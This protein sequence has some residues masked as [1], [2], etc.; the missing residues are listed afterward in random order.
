PQETIILSRGGITPE[1]LAT[2]AIGNALNFLEHPEAAL[3]LYQEGLL[4]NDLLQKHWQLRDQLLTHPI[5]AI[6]LSKTSV[7]PEVLATYSIHDIPDLFKRSE[8]ILKLHQTCPFSHDFLLKHPKLRDQLL[9]NPQQAITLSAGGMTPEVLA[10]YS[11]DDVQNFLWHPEAALALYQEGLLNNVFLQQ[12]PLLRDKFLSNPQEAITLSAGGMTPEVLATYSTDDVQNF[13]WH[14]ERALALYQEGLLNNDFLQQHPRLRD[15]FLL[16]PQ[17][18][19][20]L[21]KGGMTPEVLATYARGNALAF[22]DYPEAALALYQEGLLNNDFLQQHPRLRDEFLSNPQ[23]AITLSKGGMTPEV[24]AT[25]ST[26]DVQDFL[27]HPEAAL[28]LYQEV[29]LNNVFLQQHPELRRLFLLDPQTILFF[30]KNGISREILARYPI[31]SVK[32]LYRYPE[33]AIALHCANLLDN[34]FLQKNPQIVTEIIH[35][36]ETIIA[37]S[38]LGITPES[39]FTPSEKDIPTL[40]ERSKSINQLHQAEVLEECLTCS[41]ELVLLFIEAPKETIELSSYGI[42]PKVLSTYAMDSV[43]TLYKNPAAS[44]EFYQAGLLEEWSTHSEEFRDKTLKHA[45]YTV[46]LVSRGLTLNI[47]STCHRDSVDMLY[48]WPKYAMT[49]FTEGVPLLKFITEWSSQRFCTLLLNSYGIEEIR[50]AGISL[51]SLLS[52]AVDDAKLKLVLQYKYVLVNLK[53]DGVSIDPA[54]WD[55]QDLHKILRMPLIGLNHILPYSKR[56]T[57]PDRILEELSFRPK[58]VLLL[59]DNG[60]PV[61]RLITYKPSRIETLGYEAEKIIGLI[62]QRKV[63]FEALEQCDD[64]EKFLETFPE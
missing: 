18:T 26:D 24:L 38:K 4:N 31:T 15:E 13:L 7:T 32:T 14:P 62:K 6:I 12:H 48:N 44:M 5:E 37:L 10:T 60:L 58:P 56:K 39:L 50:K 1:I 52:D 42:T 57:L 43:R 40:C 8:E 21:S 20:A 45:K 11:T 49:L 53:K 64:L 54:Q 25:Y 34:E 36:S 55:F 46:N 41:P 19:I 2:Y 35:S 59:H 29:L 28:A 22:L 47:L 23:E 3:A 27:R 63:T 17:E 30:T 33:A 61:E 9:W 51:E 16:N